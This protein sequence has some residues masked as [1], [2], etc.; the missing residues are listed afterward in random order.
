MKILVVITSIV[1]IAQLINPAFLVAGEEEKTIYENI[2]TIRRSSIYGF[3][4]PGSLGLSFIPLLSVLIG[5]MNYTHQRYKYVFL[6]LGG[7]SAFLSNTRFVMVGFILVTFLVFLTGKDRVRGFFKYTFF[8]ICGLF[9]FSYFF[10]FIGYDITDWFND[11]LL[12]E[13][14]IRYTTRYL[15][16]FN[17]IRFFPESPFIGTGYLTDEIRIA[18]NL[19][20]SSHI[21]VGYLSHL[22]YYGI[23]G[24]FFLFGFWFL[25]LKR[26]YKT[27]KKTGYYGSIVG[28]VT[29]LFAFATMSQS[30]IFY[31]GIMF[32]FVFDKYFWDLRMRD[33]KVYKNKN[34]L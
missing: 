14:D 8:I 25:L 2:Y 18:S 4:I 3:D 16:I 20:G 9:I 33:R 13:G 31:A 26:M 34:I 27:A 30:V 19:V 32:C 28:F 6:I 7:I 12:V 29:Y 17:F 22:V 15:A 21:H 5:Y 10:R 1:S 24:C 23:F 11:R